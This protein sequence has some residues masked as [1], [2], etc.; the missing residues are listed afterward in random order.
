[1]LSEKVSVCV[2]D[3]TVEGEVYGRALRTHKG[4][5]P[6]FVSVGNQISLD[7]ACQIAMS[8]VTKES[9][10]PLPTRLADLETHIARKAILESSP[11]VVS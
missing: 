10:I 2:S 4:V 7:T 8:F 6:V 9:H 3:I 5:K 11:E 1:M